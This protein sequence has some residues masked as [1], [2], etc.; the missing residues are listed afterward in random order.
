MKLF[1]SQSLLKNFRFSI[2]EVIHTA[3][4]KV[5]SK[6]RNNVGWAPAHQ[7]SAIRSEQ[8]STSTFATV[9][10]CPPYKF[11]KEFI[12]IVMSTRQN[13][14]ETC[15]VRFTHHRKPNMSEFL[16]HTTPFRYAFAQTSYSAGRTLQMPFEKLSRAFLS[17]LLVVFCLAGSSLSLAQLSYQDALNLVQESPR[18]VLARQQLELS[19][20]QL[21]A[22]SSVVKAELSAGYTRSWGTLTAPEGNTPINEGKWDPFKLNVNFLVV[23]FG[24]RHDQVL[25]AGWDLERAR[26]ALADE[27]AATVLE[28]TQ[29]FQSASETKLELGLEQRRLEYA[30][31]SLEEIQTRLAAGAATET[32][33]NQAKAT[34]S[35]AQNTV[36]SLEGALKQALASLSQSLGVNVTD[37]QGDLPESN[38]QVTDPKTQIANRT[39][40]LEARLA[41]QDAELTN[42]ST[43]RERVPNAALTVSYD[44]NPD[45]GQYSLGAKY[46]T[47]TFQPST[48]ITLDPDFSDP[49]AVAGQTSRTF[50][51][52]ISVVIPL[53]TATGDALE[54]GRLTV[55]QRQ[56]QA[57][58]SFERALLEVQLKQL[59]ADN[60]K[61]TVALSQTNL[62]QAKTA[63]GVARQRFD[64]G[65]VGALEVLQ[66]E[67]EVQR[68]TLELVKAQNT[69]TIAH[70]ELAISLAMNPLEVY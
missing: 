34:L 12:G 23:P 21:G 49:N 68:L 13:F 33:V 1:R 67:I 43:V 28:V 11:F 5:F 31:Q 55:A 27:E 57:E 69:L 10:G 47:S 17:S 53:D 58:Q 48:F 8:P 20:R 32:D 4:E 6:M 22:A 52:G 35:Q 29:R 66:A 41:V 59:T 70:M 38:V 24:P 51:V 60:A 42:L 3:F 62:G 45:K 44:V 9:G 18:L 19:Q 64:A 65:I 37:I 39:D 36:Q 61:A 54:A 56:L 40:L 16:L 46:E 26:R 15:R 2:L 14:L 7:N 63:Q 50:N 30:E 25:R